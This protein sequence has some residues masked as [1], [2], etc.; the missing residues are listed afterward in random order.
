MKKIIVIALSLII[1]CWLAIAAAADG[2]WSISGTIPS[3]P[4]HL[5]FSTS[6]SSLTGTVDGVAITNGKAEPN[7]I[8]FSATRGGVTYNYK[9][10]IVGTK[11]SLFEEPPSGQGRLLTYLHN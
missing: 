3:A 1:G 11:L 9:G 6:G 5:S 7:T 10:T 2:A 8:W 4:Q